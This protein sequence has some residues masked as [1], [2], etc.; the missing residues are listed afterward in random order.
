MG[1][2]FQSLQQKIDQ[3][4]RRITNRGVLREEHVNQGLDL[5]KNALLEA[6]VNY[7]VVSAFL[8]ST[9]KKLLGEN[10]ELGLTPAQTFLKKVQQELSL[11]L[12][13]KEEPLARKSSGITSILLLGLQG[14]GKTTSAAKLALF[15]REQKFR[16]FLVSIDKY[17]PAAVEQL[18]ILAENYKLAG[19]FEPPK[20]KVFTTLELA[21]KKADQQ[22]ATHMIVD[23][24]GRLQIDQAMMA[25][26]QEVKKR[27][28]FQESLLVL[29]ALLGQ[30]SLSLAEEFDRVI[31][32]SGFIFTKTDGLH[33]GGAMISARAITNKPIKFVGNGEK[34]EDFMPFRPESIAS[35]ILGMADSLSLIE[36]L[37]KEAKGVEQPDVN[38]LKS[39]DYNLE[40]FAKE[41]EKMEKFSFMTDYLRQIPQLK[42]RIADKKIDVESGK[43]KMKAMRIVIQSMTQEER[44]KPNLLNASRKRRIAAGSA[45]SVADINQLLKLFQEFT[46]ASKRVLK[47]GRLDFNQLK[48]PF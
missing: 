20:D 12:G 23:T 14:S 46:T 44:A 9:K 41:L 4:L 13:E 29:D 42:N 48:R 5:I 17:R 18:A 34:P 38:R 6:D 32:I 11:L 2:I 28:S 35:E 19:F 22:D 36:R 10:L 15:L 24:A 37:E 3:S 1:S 7:R 26:L 31:N 21:Y 27:Y 25:E 30:E 43:S 8:R 16:P 47:G 45:R 33:R 39:K 40:D